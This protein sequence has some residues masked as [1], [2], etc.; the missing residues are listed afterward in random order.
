MK[1]KGN[2]YNDMIS[3]ENLYEAY[4][5]A[6]KRKSKQKGVIEFDKNLEPNLLQLHH[7]LVTKTYRTGAYTHFTV[8]DPKVRKISSLKFRDRIVH[9]LIMIPLEKVIVSTFTADTYSSVKGR[10]THKAKEALTGQL[11]NV[12]D[13]TFCLKM[14]VKQF[15]PS[16]KNA[17]IKILIRKK[18]KD[19]DLLNLL[20]EIIDS[21]EGLPI[22]NLLSQYFANLYLCYLDHVIKARFG[23]RRYCR[24]ADDMIITDSDIK[25]LHAIR[26]LI[27]EYLWCELGLELKSNYQIFPVKKRR[28]DFVGYPQDHETIQIR[29]RTKQNCF[30]MIARTPNRQS[31][32]SYKG[33]TK[34]ANCINLNKK[35]TLKYEQSIQ[36]I[37]DKIKEPDR[38]QDF[39]R[40]S[41]RQK[42]RNNRLPDRRE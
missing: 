30:R 13:T 33:C 12:A 32:A 28:I 27:E 3:M 4:R 26:A 18:I 34:H 21:A 6:R 7:E 31:L 14:D 42:N 20:D 29:K 35:I 17:I 22:G 9:H 10:G 16:V 5:R 8:R 2:I 11:K 19:K 41:T 15:Y 1:R 37:R 39:Y 23:V 25:Y 36:R 40:R 38:A 24:Y